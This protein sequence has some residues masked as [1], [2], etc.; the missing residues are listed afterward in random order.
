MVKTWFL[1]IQKN[2]ESKIKSSLEFLSFVSDS[3]ERKYLPQSIQ[4]SIWLYVSMTVGI[5]I[6]Q[7]P[8][9]NNTI[10]PH[11]DTGNDFFDLQILGGSVTFPGIS[12]IVG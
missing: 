9:I 7:H 5:N 2:G 4:P 6:R 12:G 11:R 8:Y 1:V 3:L 10:H